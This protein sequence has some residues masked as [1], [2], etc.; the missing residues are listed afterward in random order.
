M[1][2]SCPNCQNDISFSQAFFKNVSECESC[3][4]KVSVSAASR[5]IC[6]GPILLVVLLEL[7]GLVSFGDMFGKL[8]VLSAVWVVAAPWVV[9]IKLDQ[10]L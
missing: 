9:G 7:L 4:R 6:F 1:K 3:R 5:M 10:K 8:V 2:L